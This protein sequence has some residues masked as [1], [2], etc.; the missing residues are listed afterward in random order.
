MVA[1]NL[2]ILLLSQ[3]MV[4]HFRVHMVGGERAY[5]SILWVS[6]T[7]QLFQAENDYAF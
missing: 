1:I 7:Q 3:K 6:G 4:N 2:L 5:L